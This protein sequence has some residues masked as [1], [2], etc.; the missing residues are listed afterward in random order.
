VQTVTTY[1]VERGTWVEVDYYSVP[2][3]A[4][5]LAVSESTIRRLIRV[6]V[7]HPYPA[8]GAQHFSAADVAAFY[9][10]LQGLEVVHEDHEHPAA[11]LGRPVSDTDLEGLR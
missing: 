2:E 6:G 7:A 3:V 5:K 9:Q 4:A 11:E 8:T 10:A 1:D